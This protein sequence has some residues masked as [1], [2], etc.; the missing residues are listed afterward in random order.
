MAGEGG[1]CVVGGVMHG[2]SGGVC[3]VAGGMHGGGVCV[4]AGVCAWL[5]GACMVA[6]GVHSCRGHMVAGGVHVMHTPT[7]TTATAY[8]Q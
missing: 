2:G 8:S 3:M 1:P 6:G 4:V 5:R 7:D